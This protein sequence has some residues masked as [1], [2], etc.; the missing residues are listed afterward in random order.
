M[1]YKSTQRHLL[2]LMLTLLAL[3]TVCVRRGLLPPPAVAIELLTTSKANNTE[4]DG[5]YLHIQKAQRRLSIYSSGR[6]IKTYSVVFGAN[7]TGSKVA[8][9]DL[10]TPEG[11][12]QVL[13]VDVHPEWSKFIW[14]SYPNTQ[15]WHRHLLSKMRGEINLFVP[16]GGQIGIH[17]VPHG[18]DHWI[19]TQND[20]TLGCISLT[21]QDVIELS[22]FIQPGTRVLIVP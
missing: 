20:W 3:Y 9:G 18:A 4:S 14:L 16:I 21:N 17:G 8:E 2:V 10:R 19:T 11:E 13:A 6:L 15:D 5:V 12:Y 1:K 22:Q 7:H